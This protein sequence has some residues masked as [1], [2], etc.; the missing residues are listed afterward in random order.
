MSEPNRPTA[1]VVEMK[2]TLK[3]PP[4]AG[5]RYLAVGMGGCCAQVE[6]KRGDEE[7]FVCAMPYPKIPPESRKRMEAQYKQEGGKSVES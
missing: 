2:D 1:E 7:F 6:W 4:K 3:H 5:N